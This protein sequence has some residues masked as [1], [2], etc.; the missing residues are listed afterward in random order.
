MNIKQLI[1]EIIKKEFR[2]IKADFKSELKAELKAELTNELNAQLETIKAMMKPE[3]QPVP[4]RPAQPQQELPST[5]ERISCPFCNSG[6]ATTYR[7]RADIV[8]CSSCG[9]VYLRTRPTKEA[10]YQIYQVYANDTSHMRL[11]K[12]KTE[13]KSSPLRREWFVDEVLSFFS[14]NSGN[15]LD[16]GCGW[17]A[18]LMNARERGFT[19][20]G[21][22]MTRICIDYATMQLQIP[23]SNSQFTDSAVSEDS[24]RIISMVHVF[25][26]IPNPAETLA[27]IYRT[28]VPGGMFAGVVPN[29][30][31]YCSDR[32]QENW[33][34]L[35]E[36]HHYMHYSPATLRQKLEQAGFVIEKLYTSVGDYTEYFYDV[37]KGEYPA[38]S[39]D[40]LN[41][42]R[43]ELERNGKGDEIRFYVR[44]PK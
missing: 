36:T 27:K 12:S 6:T 44:K 5:M 20:M 10:L 26:H 3:V 15:W 4:E 23:V 34:W 13:I 31:S 24:C 2:R 32:Q 38:A 16:I 28:L 33:V 8:K 9:L 14:E 41:K 35:D 30:E 18:L 40:E 25:E 19:P 29:I 39:Q 22:E 17:G 43:L 21:I 42:I 37:V 7:H 11:P 1:P